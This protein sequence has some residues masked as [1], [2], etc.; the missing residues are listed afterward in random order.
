MD[1]IETCCVERERL[2]EEHA[3]VDPVSGNPVCDD[4]V[5]K[6]N[7]C[8]QRVATDKLENCE[9]ETCRD[10]EKTA[11]SLDI[12]ASIPDFRSIRY[13]ENNQFAVIHGKRLIGSNEII[14]IDRDDHSIV[15]RYGVGLVA[16]LT[17]V[18][19]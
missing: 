4:H 13:G 2:C 1:H 10:I 17:G 5:K 16:R 11:D 9:C 3:R 18:W 19:R 14:V 15:E 7:I 8:R 6:C 12:Q